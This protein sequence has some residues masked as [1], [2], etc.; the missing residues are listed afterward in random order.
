L[1]IRL[2]VLLVEDDPRDAELLLREL[3]RAGF[4]PI[5]RRVDSEEDYIEGLNHDLEII[6]SDYS[7]PGFSGVRAL[8]LLRHR[9]MEIPFIIVSGAIGESVAVDAMRAGASDYLMK[10]HLARL[11]PAIMRELQKAQDKRARRRA[12]AA[13]L[14]SEDRYRDLVENSKDLICTHDL[15]GR[16]LSVNRAAAELLGY[17]QSTLLNRRIQ[18][19][20]FRD[21]ENGFDRYIAHL[22]RSGSARGTMAVHTRTGEER[23]WEYSNTLRIDGVA[24]PI[25]RGMAHDVTEKRRAEKRLRENEAR[26]AGIVN[27]AMDGIITIDDN[28]DIVLFNPAAEKILGC[29][30]T[31]AIGLS[32]NR[33][34]P[35]PF[36]AE[37]PPGL[38]ES[39]NL[40]T[41]S[42]STHSFA[43]LT[44]LRADGEEF[45]I[46]ASIS[47][48]E[49]S[50]KKLFTVILRDITERK[51]LEEQFRQSQKM[52]AIG[53]LAGGVAHDFNNLL[54]AI[55]G[56]CQLI[57]DGLD[58]QSPLRH[59]ISEIEKAGQRA[60]A[61]TSQLLA[62]SR[63]QVLQP[64]VLDLNDVISGI[65]KMLRRLIGED[66]ELVSVMHPGLGYTR[67]DP[68]QIELIILN[69]AVNS[70]DAMPR[71]GR[72]TIGTANTELD[73]A[74]A[75]SHPDVLPGK[76][77]MLSVSDTGDGLDAETLSHIFEPFFTTKEPGK[78]TG[79]GLSTVFGI[80]KQSG[81]HISV[82]SEPGDGATFKVYL[83]W[84]DEAATPAEVGPSVSGLPTGSETILLVEDDTMVRQFARV[85]LETYGYKVL[86]ASDADAALR[87]SKEVESIDLMLTDMIMPGLT[88]R[89]LSEQLAP[90][91]PEMRVLFMSGYTD[92]ATGHHDVSEP[93]TPFLQ[94]PFTPETLARK[95]REVLDTKTN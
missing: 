42:G 64:K 81:G 67:A 17:D 7:M 15:E 10:G 58:E 28:H 59:G 6:L 87:V 48:I 14:A 78:G 61:L 46:E 34:I 68:G 77:V 12:E 27:S 86:E 83:P 94:K 63:K 53:R 43:E 70:R 41:E 39:A 29:P 13:L 91:R 84:V 89:K 35:R 38:W 11:G 18:D 37:H 44:A 95:V 55:I 76:Y 71:G 23:I 8:E 20:L 93:E 22:K 79:L 1:S 75:R 5:W 82:H 45:P 90:R 72:I 24:I 54:T 21:V 30:A 56:Y 2:N 33:F 49:V 60:A 50:R 88:G 31:E 57:Q 40:G 36:R 19:I 92:R 80:V 52:E 62:F 25:V 85:S 66:I 16:I 74:Y 73:E 47:Q 65:D 26:L 51:Q 9:E 4:D 32:I 3:R 69:L